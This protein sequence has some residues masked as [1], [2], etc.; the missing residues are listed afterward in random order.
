MGSARIC[1]AHQG[2]A[3]GRGAVSLQLL[4]RLGLPVGVFTA[5]NAGRTKADYAQDFPLP[6]P[7]PWRLL[8]LCI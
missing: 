5:V 8:T 4:I 3:V 1:S 7:S 2:L 6:P